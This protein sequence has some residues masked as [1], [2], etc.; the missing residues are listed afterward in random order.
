LASVAPLVTFAV[1]DWSSGSSSPPSTRFQLKKTWG[2]LPSWTWPLLQS[3]S[4]P[5][6]QPALI[7]LSWDSFARAPPPTSPSRVHSRP[8]SEKDD[9]RLLASTRKAWSV[10]RGFSPPRRFAPRDGFGCFAIRASRGSLRCQHSRPPP[11]GK[12]DPEAQD[13]PFPQRGHPSKNLPR[14][15]RVSTSRWPL[16]LLWL[17]PSVC[18]PEG[19]SSL[20]GPLQGVVPLTLPNC[21]TPRCRFAATAR[22][23]PWASIPTEPRCRSVVTC[24]L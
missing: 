16:A 19:D 22:V 17:P 1:A 3:A 20:L 21:L 8:P 6:N 5:L 4:G 7:R 23:L 12:P 2:M 14:Q 15:Q 11:S 13:V 9:P 10:P 24:R 18:T